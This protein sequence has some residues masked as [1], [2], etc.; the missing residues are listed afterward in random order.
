MGTETSKQNNAAI[1]NQMAHLSFIE[2][3]KHVASHYAI[4]KMFGENGKRKD[5]AVGIGSTIAA[6]ALADS[7]KSAIAEGYLAE[8]YKLPS[9]S[10][11][12]E[13]ANIA[14][15]WLFD[16]AI[17]IQSGEILKKD[18]SKGIFA[19]WVDWDSE[20]KPI[21]NEEVLYTPQRLMTELN[22]IYK[23]NGQSAPAYMNVRKEEITLSDISVIDGKRIS[24]KDTMISKVLALFFGLSFPELSC[25][26][27][28]SVSESDRVLA[29]WLFSTSGQQNEALKEG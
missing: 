29:S 27:V 18:I 26:G 17:G 25:F 4:E 19:A 2:L 20:G 1:L 3:L 9:G 15:I 12:L 6:L 11:L 21:L 10:G 16:G 7:N 13:L 5:V 23:L 14:K 8:D 24:D 28:A 22:S